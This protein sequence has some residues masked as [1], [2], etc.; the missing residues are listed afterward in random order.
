MKKLRF[1]DLSLPME[2]EA[3]EPRP[4]EIKYVDHKT[5]LETTVKSAGLPR[6][7]F[8]DEMGSA[9]EYVSVSTHSST[10]MDAP[11]HY[12]PVVEGKKARTIDQ[13]PLDWCFGDG[14]VLDM[15]HKKRGERISVNDVQ[16]ALKKID[17]KLKP[18]DIVL[19]MTGV[20]KKRNDPDY[21]KLH[22]GMGKDATL[23]LIDQGIR[24]MGIDAFGFDVP[25]DV[26]AADFRKGDKEA[27]FSSHHIAGRK[28]EYIHMEQMANLDQIPKPYGFKV[29][30]FPINI[31]KASG[32]WVRPVAI[33]EEES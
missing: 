1:I 18:G 22:P 30:C 27:L 2:N 5:F 29:A 19:I 11:W 24:V 16:E 8:Y 15:R 4:P 31:S 12:G 13:V 25:F 23:W 7:G 6:E 14:V 26:M 33:V 3:K 10:H 21:S 20:S 32:S 28:K 17:Y 9:M